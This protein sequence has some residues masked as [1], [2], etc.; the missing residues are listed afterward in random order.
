MDGWRAGL[1]GAYVGVFCFSVYR[2]GVPFERVQV[3]AWIVG[4]LLVLTAG[5]SAGRVPRLVRDWLLLGVLFVAYDL[6]RG[7]AEEL[8]MPVQIQMPITVDRALFAGHVPTVTLQDHLGP[9]TGDR[10]WEA[11]VSLVYVSH[12]VVPYAVTAALWWR[13]RPAWRQWLCRF[14]TLTVA[15]LATYVLVPTTPPWLAARNGHLPDLQ[16]SAGAGWDQLGLGIADRIVDT[17]ASTV[18][19]TAALPSLHAAYA[20]LVSV[21]LWRRVAPGWRPLLAVYPPAMAF[22]LVVTAEHYVTDIVLGWAYVAV[23]VLVWRRLER[24]AKVAAWLA[25]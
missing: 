1:V 16:R 14:A 8:G 9:F 20:L 11:L 4:G 19:L 12:F 17:G 3:L 21:F 18:N 5:S 2:R 23:V 25:S 7:V 13:S 10:W 15:G 24:R 22:T 6:S